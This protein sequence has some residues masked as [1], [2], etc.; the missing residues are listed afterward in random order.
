MCIACRMMGLDLSRKQVT[1]QPVNN[2][3]SA[4][5]A[6]GVGDSLYPNFGNGGYDA[7][8]YNVN[9][10]VSDVATSAL[11]GVTTMKATAT[12][13]LRRFNLDFIGFAIDGITVNGR[14]AT[15]TRDGQEL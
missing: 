10:N 8:R 11:T 5:G 13:N 9:L 2:S 7:K 6:A 15:F 12:Q 14:P 4:I 3:N 1:T